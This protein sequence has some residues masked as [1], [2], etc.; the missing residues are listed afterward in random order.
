MSFLAGAIVGELK[1]DKSGWNSSISSAL[2][3][4]KRLTGMAGELGDSFAKAGKTFVA[5]GGLMAGSI[6]VATQ[7]TTD[8]GDKLWDMSQRTGIS[9]ENLSRLSLVAEQSGTSLDGLAT[10]VKFLLK[11][12]ME[13]SAGN[14]E[15]RKKFE[16]LGISTRDPIEALLRLSDIISEMPEGAN[17]TGIAMEFMGRGATE[18]V[19]LLNLG[20]DAIR[21]QM[22]RADELGVTMSTKTAKACDALSDAQVELKKAVGALT[23][24]FTV[25]LLPNLLSV[26]EALTEVVLGFR[27]W[28]AE[29]P[30]LARS[31]S[32]A[33]LA[34]GG[35]L[36]LM[37]SV[38]LILPKLVMGFKALGGAVLSTTAAY[39]AVI[40]LLLTYVGLQAQASAAQD[41]ASKAA[42]R[43]SEANRQFK[44]K[45]K[46]LLLQTGM[47]VE[48][49]RKLYKEYDYNAAA[50]DAAIRRGKEG[51]E[52]QAAYNEVLRRHREEFARTHPEIKSTADTFDEL[53]KKLL[54]AK[55]PTVTLAEELGII[56]WTDLADRISKTSRALT[57]YKDKLTTAEERRLR[58]ELGALRFEF[59]TGIQLP[60]DFATAVRR[61]S[62]E[63]IPRIVDLET[64]FKLLWYAVASGFPQIAGLGEMFRHLST[65]AK[66][67]VSGVKSEM[68]ELEIFFSN[69]TWGIRQNFADMFYSIWAVDGVRAKDAL[70]GI[71]EEMKNTF[72]RCLAEMA[73]AFIVDFVEGLF[74]GAKRASDAVT[75]MDKAVS[76]VGSTV[77]T[78]ASSIGSALAGLATAIATVITTL[79]T[80]IATAIVTLAG[81]IATAL[82]TIAQGIA[83][84]ASILVAA[85]PA[86]LIILAIVLAIYAIISLV[87]AISTAIAGGGGDEVAWLKKIYDEVCQMRGY[88]QEIWG[89]YL[90]DMNF[91]LGQTAMFSK[92]CWEVLCDVFRIGE[93]SL[94][95]LGDILAAIKEIE[96]AQGGAYVERDSLMYVHKGEYIGT[97]A[98]LPKAMLPQTVQIFI[99]GEEVDFP[100]EGRVKK[101]MLK[102][103]PELTNREKLKIHVRAVKGRVY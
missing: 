48:E 25:G 28:A 102:A 84:A 17:K 64:G 83:T 57:E 23:R 94:W 78:V 50:M 92:G 67:G 88:V 37:G 53:I 99:E 72:L 52:L 55:E 86:L 22:Q 18:L 90:P 98:M 51:K 45:M 82:I 4:G 81:A 60:G 100:I 30:V 8:F 38:L 44:E 35:L 61:M 9:V 47:T 29:H 41:S 93:Q 12:Q 101:I 58:M 34:A 59:D 24:E 14:E 103:I 73:A 6:L 7:K 20:S 33:G 80:A 69:L 62:V 79:A 66:E 63:S 56:Q 5:A 77:S 19:P 97:P 43:A 75:S 89:G 49:F 42:D 36:T 68:G 16:A 3:D 91:N 39:G 40:P 31:I 95:R 54:A 74:K 26:T 2:A 46:E 87:S 1:L 15:L 27:Q 76:A 13:A 32:T 10:S 65:D 70:N 96:S 85:L 21:L 71:W 11:N